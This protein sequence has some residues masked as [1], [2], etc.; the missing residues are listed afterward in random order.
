MQF[1]TE[2]SVYFTEPEQY[3]LQIDG[4]KDMCSKSED[5]NFQFT[6][7]GVIGKVSSI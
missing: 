3:E 7:F 1:F 5:I 4:V 2:Q 6:G